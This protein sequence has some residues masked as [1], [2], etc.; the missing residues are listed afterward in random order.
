MATIK[1]VAKLAGVGTSTVSRYFNSSGYISEDAREKIKKACDELNYTPNELARAMKLNHTKT[2]GVMIPTICNPFFTELVHVIEQK[3]LKKG[4]KTVLCNTNGDL[5]LEQNYLNLAM[6]NRFDGIILITGSFE[7]LQLKTKIPMILLDRIDMGGKPHISL[8]SNNRQG[9]HL[10]T[11]Y[12]IQCGCRKLMYL[13]SEEEII[14]AKER[15]KGF[16]EI[17]KKHEIPFEICSSKDLDADRLKSLIDDGV[18]GIFAWNDISAVQVLSQCA[19]AGIRIPE[20]VQLIGYD[21]IEMSEMVYPK[22]TTIEQPTVELGDL[23]S[24]HI[25]DLIDGKI[26]PPITIELDNRLVVRQS[27]KNPLKDN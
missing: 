26:H 12:L 18:D 22:L 25:I 23:A 1:E 7:F 2:I 24:Q 6:S 10:A 4:Y 17:A 16:L 20:Q 8:T 15:M 3:L 11:E 27:T 5:E 14:P 21:N 13:D 19:M 9:A